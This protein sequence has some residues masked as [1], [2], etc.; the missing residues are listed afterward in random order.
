M[1]KLGSA[2]VLSLSH[3]QFSIP[4]DVLPTTWME[5]IGLDTKKCIEFVLLFIFTNF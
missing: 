1:E 4:F 2:T 5:I 3:I